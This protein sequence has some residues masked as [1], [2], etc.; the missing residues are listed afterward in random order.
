MSI[1]QKP[2]ARSVTGFC[3]NGNVDV[4]NVLKQSTPEVVAEKVRQAICDAAEGGGFILGTSHSI[5][6]APAANV[7]AYFEAARH[8]GRLGHRGP[9]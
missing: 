3:L 6:E 2:S 1:W 4:V 8:F 5:R 9:R 7:R